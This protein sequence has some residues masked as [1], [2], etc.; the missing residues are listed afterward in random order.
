M[1]VAVIGGGIGG[2]TL[3]LYLHRHGIPCRVYEAV[4]EFKP[5][6]V[7]INLFPHAMRR[8]FETIDRVAAA[9]RGHIGTGVLNRLIGDAVAAH[10]PPADAGGRRLRLFYATQPET[11]PP[12]VVLFVNEPSRMSDSYRRYLEHAI[13]S[14]FDLPGVPLRIVLRRRRGEEARV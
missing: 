3:A 6:G 14:G 12:T 9:H 8:L 11:K 10:E 4:T 1:E 5:L 2:L 7:G 13:R